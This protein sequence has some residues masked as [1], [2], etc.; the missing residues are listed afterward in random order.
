[1]YNP[2]ITSTTF[3]SNYIEFSSSNTKVK[4]FWILNKSD[5]QPVNTN[6]QFSYMG[7]IRNRLFF[8]IMW[9]K[10][11]FATDAMYCNDTKYFPQKPYLNF[12]GYIHSWQTVGA[13]TPL[14]FGSWNDS[15]SGLIQSGSGSDHPE[16]SYFSYIGE[17]ELRGHDLVKTL[18][19]LPNCKNS[20][21][22]K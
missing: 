15:T 4:P 16:T 1:L 14:T 6:Q 10:G 9:S 17:Y 3:T 12:I 13:S 2:Q 11:N 8:S 7:I 22:K 19:A 18:G 21:I 5:S 20:W